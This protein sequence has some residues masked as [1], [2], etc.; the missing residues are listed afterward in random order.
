MAKKRQTL[1]ILMLILVAGALS[2][3][4]GLFDHWKAK[5]H[6]NFGGPFNARFIE[7]LQKTPWS[8]SK[9][10][11]HTG[12]E[13][14]DPAQLNF[15]RNHPPLFYWGLGGWTSIFGNKEWA[16]RSFTL[17]FSLLNIFLVFLISRRIWPGDAKKA[18]WAAFFQ[19]AFLGGIY[20]GTHVD[21]L[22]EFT[23]TFWLLGVLAILLGHWWLAIAAG[24][25][26]G[27]TDWPGFFFVGG[28]VVLA[29]VLK[30]NQ[31]TAV[32]GLV[33]TG[34]I[35]LGTMMYLQ[36]TGDFFQWLAD[37]LSAKGY[38]TVVP[39]YLV[40]L[41]NLIQHFS[42]L[43]GPLF[44]A[45][46]FY[47]LVMVLKKPQKKDR[48]FQVVCLL[49]ASS[50]LL[51]LVSH[52]YVSVHIFWLMPVL[53]LFALLCAEQSEKFPPTNKYLFLS[54][55]LL[56]VLFYPYGIYQSSFAHDVVN[57]LLFCGAALLFLVRKAKRNFY[58]ALVFA[59]AVANASQVINYRNEKDSEYVFCLQA[60]LEHR[61]TGQ[62]VK[63]RRGQTPANTY[64]C[65]EV[66]IQY[67][68]AP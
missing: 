29:F 34:L 9:G 61:V 59:T 22:A 5:D 15:Y 2:R 64:Y 13:K 52:K 18:L 17:L 6:Y 24:I 67:E 25:L 21:V 8:I 10:I 37:K 30:K 58:I 43:L 51:L 48:F 23:G 39:N 7:C 19:A 3:S 56:F 49:A 68:E 55:I 62:P 38:E 12:C 66:P 1:F 26:S 42:R 65:G 36:Q 54:F 27:L 32:A 40:I 20:F 31:K 50:L 45:L 28:L 44:A 14:N 63:A 35:I 53:P 60:R 41:T 16:Y 57:S 47:T 11:P 4:Y 46:G 33:L